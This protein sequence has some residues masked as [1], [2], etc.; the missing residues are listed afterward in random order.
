MIFSHFRWIDAILPTARQHRPRLS[1]AQGTLLLLIGLNLLNY[2][3]RYI[4]PGEVSL[5]QREF[6]STDQQMGWLTTALFFFYMIAAPLT[7]WLSNRIPAGIL[8]GI[9][10]A[11]V[12][13]AGRPGPMHRP[14]LWTRCSW[15]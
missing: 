5:I 2:I 7:G 3:D 13:L 14:A 1:P 10:E 8:G 12:V 9:E 15:R 6:H 4:L 11:V